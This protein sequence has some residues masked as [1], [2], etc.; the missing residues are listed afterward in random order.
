M[1]DRQGIPLVAVL[2]G[3]NRHD[4]ML[5]ERLITAIP[6]IKTTRGGRRKR[7]EKLHADKGY[8]FPRCRTF[9]GRR[10][11]KCRIARKGIEPKDRLGRH[12]WVVERT[13]A[14]LAKY[15]RLTIRYERRADIHQAFLSLGCS[16]ICANFLGS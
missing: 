11:I 9:L 12:R 15:R 2:S 14:W 3:A 10:G 4:S 7:P 8:D 1:V 16:L 13:F 6:P 5:V